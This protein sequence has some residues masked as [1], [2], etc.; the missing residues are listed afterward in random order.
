LAS[1]L[2]Q[3]PPG[4]SK[5]LPP[6]S[7][8]HMSG[9]AV[10]EMD[11]P[12]VEFWMEPYIPKGKGTIVLCHGKFGTYK[13][14]ITTNIAKAIA[15]GDPEIFNCKLKP[16]KVLYVQADSPKQIIVPRLKL[17]DVA[18]ENL[19]FNFCNPGPNIVDPYKD[20]LDAFYY[21]ILQKMHRQEGYDV[22][23]IDALRGIHRL[24]DKEA[25][26]VHTVYGALLK[27]FYGATIVIIHH[28]KKANPDGVPGD[29][30]FSGSQA[31]LNHATVGLKFSHQDRGSG[32]I[33]IEH[34][35]SQA[36]ELAPPLTISLKD[37]IFAKSLQEAELLEV[38]GFIGQLID[39][40]TEDK[41]PTAKQIDEQVSEHF[42]VSIRTARRRRKELEGFWPELEKLCGQR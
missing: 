27:L 37:G 21:A 36:S 13:T 25:T 38:K 9:K 20:E 11:L 1:T 3:I 32:H 39:V 7:E 6:E 41:M 26:S 5:H 14:P 29:E 31:W 19:D 40:A 12:E 16:G 23:F 30:S 17:L 4:I 22:V 34:T 15:K 10:Q 42:G 18:I 33:K 2:P 8:I 28:D 35:K 24:D